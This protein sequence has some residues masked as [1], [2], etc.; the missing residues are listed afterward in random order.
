[1]LLFYLEILKYIAITAMNLLF[2]L[3]LMPLRSD[4]RRAKQLALGGCLLM[5]VTYVAVVHFL[6][7]SDTTASLFLLTLPS[8]LFF[9]YLSEFR[10]SRF[11]LTFCMVDILCY[12]IQFWISLPQ[13]VL[14]NLY[15]LTISC[16]LA[17]ICI[18]LVLRKLQKYAP[19]YKALL[20][21]KTVN[22][23]YM[24]LA[25]FLSYV[26]IFMILSYP[27]SIFNRLEYLPLGIACS[28]TIGAIFLVI[29]QSLIK[30]QHILQQKEKLEQEKQMF[31]LAYM[32][33]LTGLGN[34][35]AYEERKNTL[36]REKLQSPPT[37]CV[38]IDLNG[39]KLVND[40]FGHA[41]GD[42][43]IQSAAT[44]LRN[45]FSEHVSSIFRLGGDEF[46][47]LLR[48]VSQQWLEERLTMLA[49]E[50]LTD[51]EGAALHYSLAVGYDV[52]CNTPDDCIEKAIIRA[53]QNMYTDKLRKKQT[54][55]KRELQ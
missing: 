9:L 11:V 15:G 16:V 18:A 43:I 41:A 36:E 51:A 39:L 24:A 10:D 7:L 47:L 4:I 17:A 21:E 33:A 22:W 44:V 55:G 34:R 40:T 19:Q 45:I 46:A 1:M 54:E 27:D 32:D 53:D 35:A 8:I 3:M 52:L 31:Q 28:L 30:T 49:D 23:N 48:G 6:I 29:I 25:T 5:L 42:K 13:I 12:N 14:P 26:L 37:Y 20:Q 38:M 50:Q 2:F